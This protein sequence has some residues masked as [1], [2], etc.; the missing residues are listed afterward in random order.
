MTQKEK[1]RDSPS[2]LALG[3]GC[4]SGSNF[5]FHGQDLMVNPRSDFRP[6]WSAQN[7]DLSDS[8]DLSSLS[9]KLVIPV[10]YAESDCRF[11]NYAKFRII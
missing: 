2:Y 10:R 9:L 11:G 4:W 7:P 8:I 3:K 6:V 1:N 5:G